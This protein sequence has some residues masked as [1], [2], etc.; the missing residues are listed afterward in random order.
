MSRTIPAGVVEQEIS[1]A[2]TNP[3]RLS[4]TRL[5]VFCLLLKDGA[6][7][8]NNV[9]VGVT[10]PPLFT[11]PREFSSIKTAEGYPLSYDLY[12]IYVQVSDIADKLV[13]SYIPVPTS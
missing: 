3:K 13:I 9:K 12:D 4:A 2:D 1:F 5:K 6:S 8:S 7:N 10:N 11:S